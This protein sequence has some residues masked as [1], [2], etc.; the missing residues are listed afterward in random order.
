MWRAATYGGHTRAYRRGRS[1]HMFGTTVT[2][3]TRHLLMA[4]GTLGF[5]AAAVWAPARVGAQQ[6]PPTAVED[7]FT[8]RGGEV[9]PFAVRIDVQG[10]SGT[11]ELPNGARIAT[12]TTSPTLRATVTNVDT[13]EQVDLNIPG[14]T[15]LLGTG[16]AVFLGPALVIRSPDFGDDTTGLV[17]VAGRYT[18]LS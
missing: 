7:T 5:V 10:K 4:L 14:P 15:Q 2:T 6:A 18:F 17:Y 1:T 12:I 3:T 8:F 9:C 13:G 16:E 11:L